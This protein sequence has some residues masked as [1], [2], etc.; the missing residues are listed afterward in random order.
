MMNME[1]GQLFRGR[2]AEC[3]WPGFWLDVEEGR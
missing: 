3:Y 1:M 2:V